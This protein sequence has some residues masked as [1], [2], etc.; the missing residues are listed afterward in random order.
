MGLRDLLEHIRNRE[1]QCPCCHHRYLSV[2]ERFDQVL[3]VYAC[4]F[5]EAVAIS[6]DAMMPLC[7]ENYVSGSEEIECIGVTNENDIEL[8]C[9]GVMLSRRCTQMTSDYV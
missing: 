3:R 2:T 4:D 5:E 1:R 9:V 8:L 7:D 6:D